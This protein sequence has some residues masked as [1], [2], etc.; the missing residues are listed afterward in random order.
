MGEPAAHQPLVC[1]VPEER[2]RFGGCGAD[3]ARRRI[4]L[5]VTTTGS[6]GD[7]ALTA[8]DALLRDRLR[9]FALAEELGRVRAAGRG[10]PNAILAVGRAAGARVRVG[11]PGFGPARISAECWEPAFAHYL[12]PI[13]VGLRLD[14][15]RFLD[16]YNNRPSTHRPAQPRSHTRPSPKQRT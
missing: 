16:Y 1:S 7:V 2:R 14:L 9:V 5:L 3:V 12:T 15:D 13:Y 8:D 10:W 6:K 11:Y 4:L